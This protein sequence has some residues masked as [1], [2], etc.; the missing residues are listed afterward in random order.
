[1]QGCSPISNDEKYASLNEMAN[2]DGEER[3][4]DNDDPFSIAQR[5]AQFIFPPAALMYPSN[6]VND[7]RDLH[8]TK[9]QSFGRKH[10]WDAFFGRR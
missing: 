7:Y 4:S 5:S 9:R 1:M 3:G 2:N 6:R 8:G 10:H